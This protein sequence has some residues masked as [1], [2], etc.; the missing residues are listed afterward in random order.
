[1]Q[2]FIL[3]I[4]FIT[5]P[6]CAHVCLDYTPVQLFYFSLSLEYPHESRRVA[7]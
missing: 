7:T 6:P 5:I 1:M 4:S 3:N 2:E